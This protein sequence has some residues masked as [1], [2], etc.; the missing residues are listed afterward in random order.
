MDLRVTLQ[1]SVSRAMQ[2]SRQQSD[3]YALLSEQASSGLKFQS[4]PD[5]PLE[6]LNVLSN[7]AHDS[8][9]DAYLGNIQDARTVLE[10]G[11]TALRN[12]G[13][14]LTKARQLAI[15]GAHSANDQAAREGIATEVDSLLKRLIDVANTQYSGQYIFGGTAT[16][17]VPFKLESASA[18]GPDTVA[19]QGSA[20][21]AVTSVSQNESVV[22]FYTGGELF[23][24]RQRGTTV[25]AGTTGAKPGTGTDGAT[26]QGALLVTHT[27]TTFAAG[28]GLL[29]GTSSVTGDTVI[30]PA[31][32]TSSRSS[33]RVAP[34]RPARSRSTAGPRS[35]SRT[36]ARTSR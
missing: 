11:T 21:R 24:S 13:T 33:T 30:G 18:A 14:I 10:I 28:S 35:P 19:Y 7:K 34:G 17:T 31:G 5:S 23:Q 36:R 25:Y 2:Y 9:L 29:N 1:T 26:G 15:E 12:A 16:K 32:R 6:A 20:D 4:I 27:A 3:Q 8:R 22:K